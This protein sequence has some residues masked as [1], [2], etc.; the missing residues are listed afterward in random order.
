MTQLALVLDNIRSAHNV[1]AIVRSAAAFG[2]SELIAIGI[3]PYPKLT[4]DRRLP[5]VADK[6]E[7]M[8]AKTALGAEK[9]VTFQYFE[10][11]E[12]AIK[13][14][15]RRGQRVYALE[16]AAGA[17]QLGAFQPQTAC[18]LILGNEV[19]GVASS[20]LKDCDAIIEIPLGG[21][22]ESLNVAAAAGIAMYDFQQ[23][24]QY[25]DVNQQRN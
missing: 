16:Q 19:N 8:I 24:L 12:L 22:K 11:L 14:M 13:Y 15:R 5:H 17:Y 6:A 9:Q 7:R 2:I 10:K 18:A 25:G 20:A 23:K 4:G 1:G 21:T 3:T